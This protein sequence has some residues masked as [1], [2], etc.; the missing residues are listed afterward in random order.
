MTKFLCGLF[1][2]LPD[3]LVKFKKLIHLFKNFLIIN[4]FQV[5]QL[6]TEGNEL[7]RR[8]LSMFFRTS[9]SLPRVTPVLPEYQNN[10]LNHNH[11]PTNS[12][13]LSG[14][15]RGRGALRSRGSGPAGSRGGSNVV[16]DPL[17]R[18]P[19]QGALPRPPSESRG[20][21]P[22][23]PPKVPPRTPSMNEKLDNVI[24]H[25]NTE[26]DENENT[27]NDPLVISRT[28]SDKNEIILNSEV[29][30]K[31]ENEVIAHS[32][33]EIQEIIPQ[34]NL[35]K[36]QNIQEKKEFEKETVVALLS[37]L[38]LFSNDLLESY[39][40]NGPI[41]SMLISKFLISNLNQAPDRLKLNDDLDEELRTQ[42]NS[43]VMNQI[44]EYYH[45]I[46]DSQSF[47]KSKL[48]S[49][50]TLKEK[51]FAASEKRITKIKRKLKRKQEFKARIKELKLQNNGNDW[52]FESLINRPT[53]EQLDEYFAILPP[54]DLANSS[55]IHQIFLKF[56]GITYKQEQQIRSLQTIPSLKKSARKL[57]RRTRELIQI[58]LLQSHIDSQHYYLFDFENKASLSLFYILLTRKLTN[59]F[60]SLKIS[61]NS[62]TPR[63][64]LNL[65]LNTLNDLLNSFISLSTYDSH[66]NKHILPWGSSLNTIGPLVFTPA[67]FMSEEYQQFL[68][69]NNKSFASIEQVS[70]T[71][72]SQKLEQVAEQISKLVCFRYANCIS[73]Y[74]LEKVSN[75]AKDALTRIVYNFS[76]GGKNA[77]ESLYDPNFLTHFFPQNGH[78][79]KALYG[80]SNEYSDVWSNKTGI[81][82][83]SYSPPKFYTSQATDLNLGWRIGTEYEANFLQM[84][85]VAVPREGQQ[86][87]SSLELLLPEH[88]ESLNKF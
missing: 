83:I 80:I 15:D 73:N 28:V 41:T 48:Q 21:P 22:K 75:L 84:K 7:T 86:F 18:G 71:T 42:L 5:S 1:S 13:R 24:S 11:S 77:L 59:Y 29:D 58:H 57:S 76:K 38:S 19:P 39:F 35:E 25:P 62:S 63:E 20:P 87:F 61:S 85:S 50:I 36:S 44:S 88:Q 34:N 9:G 79:Q 6:K 47:L 72:F 45:F 66:T 23:A 31:V 67:P 49:Q 40:S 37:E 68:R 82:D 12:G 54:K 14:S 10:I 17:P 4:L 81:V 53:S 70:F 3:D 2:T 78:Y 26:Q 55:V 65:Q 56:R 43:Y 27:A 74:P 32:N 52:E 30:I 51:S 33:I 46:N 64:N 16:P 8:Q 60:I 69:H